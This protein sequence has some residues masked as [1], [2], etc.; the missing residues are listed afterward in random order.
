[1]SAGR[2]VPPAAVAPRTRSGRH[3]RRCV[4]AVLPL[5]ATLATILL[6]ACAGDGSVR[7]DRPA[8]PLASCKV[9]DVRVASEAACLRDD[10]ACYALAD[11]AWCTGERGNRCPAGSEPLPSG[12]PCPP[13]VRCFTIGESLICRVG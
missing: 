7:P 2:R 4:G 13:G 9:G 12:V 6:G 1:M 3:G 10:A 5:A 8:S 11:G